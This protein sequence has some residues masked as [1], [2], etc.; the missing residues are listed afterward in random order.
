MVFRIDSVKLFKLLNIDSSFYS[1]MAV[2]RQT[3]VGRWIVVNHNRLRLCKQGLNFSQCH[4][5]IYQSAIGNEIRKKKNSCRI[6]LL[7]SSWCIHIADV[8]L[9]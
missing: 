9:W 8:W 6:G 7:L 1:F 2:A 5:C 3:T 4:F